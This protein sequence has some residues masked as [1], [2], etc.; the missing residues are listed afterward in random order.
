[1]GKQTS[2]DR[3]A[4]TR[5][6]TERQSPGQ[7]QK[8]RHPDRDKA[9]RVYYWKYRMR[10]QMKETECSRDDENL[11]G[12]RDGQNSRREKVSRKGHNNR[13]TSRNGKKKLIIGDRLTDKRTDKQ[14]DKQTETQ[15]DA[16][17]NIHTDKQADRYT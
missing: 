10:R 9:N 1:M 11:D 4:D 17:T 8:D 3:E 7:R 13:R 15:T 6:E 5:T 14:A 2:S 16:Q 12:L